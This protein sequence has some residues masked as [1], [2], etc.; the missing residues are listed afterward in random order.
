MGGNRRHGRKLELRLA[1]D[2]YFTDLARYMGAGVLWDDAGWY[3]EWGTWR[4]PEWGELTPYLKR[5]DMHFLVWFPTFMAYPGSRA[6]EHL[7]VETAIPDGGPSYD[8]GI[9]Q[10]QPAAT[11]WQRELLDEKVA[12]WGDF[13]W[14]WDGAPGWGL[15]PLAADQQFRTLVRDF[16]AEHP[17]CAIDA[18]SVGGA[19]WMGVDLAGYACSSEMVDGQGVRDYA[20]YH[21]SML[22][23]PDLPHWIILAARDKEPRKRYSINRD[24]AHLRMHPVWFGDPGTTVPYCKQ[25]KTEDFPA[26]EI[27]ALRPQSFPDIEQIRYDWDLYRYLHYQEVVGRWSHVFRPVVS[28]DEPVLYFQRMNR[29]GTKG[30]VLTTRSWEEPE[31]VPDSPVT[32]FPKGLQ[33]DTRYMVGFDLDART[34]RRSGEE[35]MTDG[36]RIESLRPGEIVYLNLPGHPGSGNDQTPPAPPRHVTL[37]RDTY[38]YTQGMA[39]EWEPGSDD[40]WLSG[41][42]VFRIGP[43]GEEASLGRVSRGTFLFDRSQLARELESFRYEVCS[44]DGD[45]NRSPRVAAMET[46]GKP[47]P[48]K[49]FGFS[50]FAGKQGYR[51]WRYEWSLDGET[52][53]P[54]AWN[55]E[56]GYEGRWTTPG[57][58]G[59]PGPG[60]IGRTIMLPSPDLCVA[61]TLLAPHEG[62]CILRG[63]IRRDLPPGVAP[64]EPCRVRVLVDGKQVW[65][66]EGWGRVDDSSD[67]VS[68][69]AEA[70]VVRGS[71]IVHLVDPNR[72]Y[73][74]GGIAWNPMVEYAEQ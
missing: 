4:S 23:P 50:G 74:S 67:G 72:D 24:R 71:R 48:E 29:D 62:K 68:Y 8:H 73:A 55:A 46:S 66:K 57:T 22:I 49:H 20:G 33:P 56:L 10:S 21:S 63:V 31:R 52:F 59:T 40:N 5:H 53:R 16:M 32:V 37:Q 69:M 2:L 42:E 9:D 65:P 11:A 38:V 26:D 3:D 34:E 45:G 19:S 35:L 60:G 51:G 1:L 7:G 25:N 64:G 61:R 28:G 6:V 47:Q 18:G 41:Y 17:E 30:V 44:I 12:Q 70:T 27:T 58:L 43:D 14:R 54:L 15:D 13:Q 36:I 39:I